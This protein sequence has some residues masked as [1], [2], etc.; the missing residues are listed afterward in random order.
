[1]NFNCLVISHFHKYGPKRKKKVKKRTYLE[2]DQIMAEREGE[3]ALG[4]NRRRFDHLYWTTK[5]FSAN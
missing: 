4:L 5:W 2:S 3:R 1:M